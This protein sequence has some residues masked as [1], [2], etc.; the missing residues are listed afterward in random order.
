MTAFVRCPITCLLAGALWLAAST[1]R[2]CLAQD[3][4]PPA[5][6]GKLERVLDSL[7]KDGQAWFGQGMNWL[8]ERE[9]VGHLMFMARD[10]RGGTGGGGWYRPSVS[11]Y[12]WKWFKERF[13]T[14]GDGEVTLEEFGGPAVWFEALDKNR[15]GALTR[16]D[17][18]WFGDASLARAVGKA[19]ALFS[20][21]DADGNG[22]VTSEEWQRW[23]EKLSGGRDYLAQDDLLSI[24]MEKKG[25]WGAGKKGKQKEQ[26]QRSK[27]TV[28]CSYIAGDVGSLAEGPALNEKAPYFTLTTVD[29]KDKVD[30]SKHRGDK[31]L[32]L[33]FGSFT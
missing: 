20:Q 17:F 14:D 19:K 18:E 33:I 32:V 11:R 16:E 31:P 24:F 8:L 9:A 22:Q 13:D 2:A 1:E 15:D 28:F 29:G 30:L 21:I 27:L 23:F 10:T 12:D 7:Q 3:G 25:N 26:P 4:R 6:T 5:P